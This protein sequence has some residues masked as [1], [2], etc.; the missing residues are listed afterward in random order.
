L[1]EENR[2]FA[3]GFLFPYIAVPERKKTVIPPISPFTDYESAG[4][5]D[6]YDELPIWS[7]PFGLHLLE[8]IVLRDGI[9]V[10]D[11]GSGCGFPA[12]ELAQ[13]MG[14][15]CTVTGI[16]PS[17]AGLAR[18][19]R[20]AALMGIAHVSFIPGEA[21][22]LPFTDGR[23]GLV[24]SNNGINNVRDQERVL[25]ECARVAAPEAQFVM[26]ANLPGTMGS[27][28]AIFEHTLRECGLGDFV[29]VMR[30]HIEEKRKPAGY[31]MTLLE[32]TGW[33]VLTCS[34]RRFTMRYADGTTMLQH[35]FIR[36]AFLPSWWEIVPAEKRTSFFAQLEHGLN[37]AASVDG[38]ELDIPFV[39][40]DCRKG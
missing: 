30:A 25:R 33:R 7:A 34:E 3:F 21:E 32:R 22:Q 40:I 20:K 26:T 13:R 5:T 39:C 38:V 35:F 18:A 37:D 16:D 2:L 8:R 10:L 4:F 1:T 9:N 27:F 17:E 36:A 15:H 19:C 29:G 6:V 23:F 11:I 12:L 14:R 24:T 31:L 28:Y